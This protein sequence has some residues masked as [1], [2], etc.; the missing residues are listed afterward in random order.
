MYTAAEMDR[1]YRPFFTQLE[2]QDFDFTDSRTVVL[3][4]DI[5]VTIRAVTGVATDTMGNTRPEISTVETAVW[6]KRSGEWKI[7]IGH[8]SLQKKSWQ[9]WLDFEASQ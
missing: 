3:A 7:L 2:S 5:A 9:G 4:P 1:A 6:V 8:E